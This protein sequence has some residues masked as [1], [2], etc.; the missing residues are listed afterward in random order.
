MKHLIILAALC[1]TRVATLSAQTQTA[2]NTSVL[3]LFAKD[4]EKFFVVLDGER[5]NAKAAARV[6]VPN[7]ERSY[8]KVKVIFE[9]DKLGA[10]DDN[11]QMEGVDSR[12]NDVTYQIRKKKKGERMV[13]VINN[14]SFVPIAK[15]QVATTTDALGGEDMTTPAP[16]AP[17]P[18][19][20]SQTT[21]TQTETMPGGNINMNMGMNTTETGI[22]T[23]VTVTTP[24]EEKV[25]ME[26][27]VQGMGNETPGNVNSHTSVTTTS[28]STRTTTRASG[29]PKQ[30]PATPAQ[31]ARPATVTPAASNPASPQAGCNAPMVSAAFTK[32]VESL[33]KTAFEDTRKNM[34]KLMLKSN[35]L[36]TAQVRQVM[37]TMSFEA[38]KLEFAKAAYAHCTDKDNY[39]QVA[40]DFSFNSSKD[41]LLE[42]M[43]R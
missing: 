10:I 4:G 12:Y 7:L 26:V 17:A 28:S 16:A 38:S 34:A 40:D 24:E 42:V 14:Y 23:N 11:L 29:L 21:I 22:G 1:L 19:E 36:S 9:D 32:Q 35:C 31:H 43:S 15:T 25:N 8:Y 13:Y 27:N 39:P 3:T 18:T 33:K 30:T 41:E 37:K 20:Q 5:R 6:V 2:P